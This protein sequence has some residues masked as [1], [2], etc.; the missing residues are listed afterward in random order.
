[1][2]MYD[3][4]VHKAPLY[5]VTRIF[6]NLELEITGNGIFRVFLTLIL[7]RFSKDDATSKTT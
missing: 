7:A 1:M 5:L 3:I 4:L 2:Q 6:E